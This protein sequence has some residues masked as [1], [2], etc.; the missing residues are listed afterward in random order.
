MKDPKAS[1]LHLDIIASKR[2]SL[3]GLS[4]MLIML[5]HCGCLL[6]SGSMWKC[7][8]H[9]VIGVELFAFLSGIGISFS[10][11]KDSS[12]YRFYRKRFLRIAPTYVAVALP[13]SLY[14]HFC[15]DASWKHVVSLTSG[16]AT[17]RGDITYWFISFIVLCYLLAPLLMGFRNHVRKPFA[18]TIAMLLVSTILFLLLEQ[19]INRC[20]IWILR[21]PAF[22]LGLDIYPYICSG[23]GIY[24]ILSWRRKK[25]SALLAL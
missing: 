6:D 16:L 5:Y 17:L 24:P 11:A 14:R 9:G 12:L 13:L 1:Q 15:L 8:R 19:K 21:F 7:F 23:G 4:I 2:S 10:W 18:L 25:G 3:M 22:C 20:D